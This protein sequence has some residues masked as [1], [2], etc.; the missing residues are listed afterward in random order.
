MLEGLTPERIEKEFKAMAEW[1]EVL[2]K[3]NDGQKRRLKE[4]NAIIKRR[5]TELIC[6]MNGVQLRETQDALD[7][8]SG[9]LQGIT[10]L[11]EDHLEEA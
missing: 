5:D 10:G 6:Y 4:L 8:V 11:I 3:Q 2:Q 1:I 7:K 9:V